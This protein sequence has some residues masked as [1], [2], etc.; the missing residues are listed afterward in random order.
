[1]DGLGCAGQGRRHRIPLS[2]QQGWLNWNVTRARAALVT[3]KTACL[4]RKSFKVDVSSHGEALT[5]SCR[6]CRSFQSYDPGPESSPGVGM[7]VVD[8]A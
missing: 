6:S 1:M 7:K 3:Q 8:G 2:P 4:R 5:R